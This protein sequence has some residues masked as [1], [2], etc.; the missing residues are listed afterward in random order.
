MRR[1]DTFAKSDAYRRKIH[2]LIPGGAHTYSKGDDQFPLRS[3]AAFTHGKGA[4]L[5]DLDGNQYLDF[6]MGLASVSLGHAYE[7]VNER[8]KRQIDLGTNF[9][10]PAHIEMEVAERFTELTAVHSMIKFAKNGST[11][12]SAA[13]KLA[14]AFTGKKLV[15]FPNNQ[16]FFSYDDWFIGKTACPRGVPGF[17]SDHSVTFDG[18]SIGSLEKLFVEQGADIACVITEVETDSVDRTS[19]H[20]QATELCHRYGALYVLDEMKSGYHSDFPG[21][22]TKFGLKPDLATWGKGIANG[23]SF[24]ALT[25]V[26]EVMELGG[27]RRSG[28]EKLFL[29]STTHGAETHGLAAALATMDVYA[30]NDVIGHCQS[31]CKRAIADSKEM[32]AGKGLS[33][34]ICVEPLVW[35]PSYSFLDKNG[36]VSPGLKTL[37][38]QEMIA[39]GVLFQG[40]VLP[41]Y[42]HTIADMEYYAAAFEQSLDVIARALEDGFEAYLEGPALQ[43]V[44][45]R[46]I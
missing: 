30:H 31:L 43:P 26:P 4:Y 37:M 42:S 21:A 3:P 46:F 33:D 7:A 28:V 13:V 15:A 10:R 45:R 39:R 14:R 35:M 36:D 8:V 5:W 29:I 19:F 24:C 32:I 34:F 40:F 1:I 25:G 17:I 38:M 20:Q 12:T 11:V 27:I 18:F 2:D 44:F 41:C 9:Q 16:P 23:Y 6:T 22:I